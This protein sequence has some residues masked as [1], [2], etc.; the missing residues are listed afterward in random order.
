[1]GG[2]S[3]DKGEELGGGEEGGSGEG[4]GWAR[5]GRRGLGALGCPAPRSLSRR[6]AD[7]RNET[8]Q[9]SHHERC[10]SCPGHLLYRRTCLS[11]L[12][13]LRPSWLAPLPL[14]F[15][16]SCSSAGVHLCLVR[17]PSQPGIL[18]RPVRGFQAPNP[19]GLQGQR[20]PPS[21]RTRPCRR[22]LPSA[23]KLNRSYLLHLFFQMLHT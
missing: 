8:Y 18:A 10:A 22:T 21:P 12:L 14:R 4:G 6:N 16:L 3:D 9:K 17:H 13:C 5:I 20:Q 7:R 15:P 2:E 1:V 23:S 11:H 19:H